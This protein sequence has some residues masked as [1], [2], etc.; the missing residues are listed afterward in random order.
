MYLHLINRMMLIIISCLMFTCSGHGSE[1]KEQE[2][3]KIG[4]T[5]PASSDVNENQTW[6]INAS[7]MLDVT[8]TQMSKSVKDF[9]ARIDTFFS[10]DRSLEEEN[11]DRLRLRLLSRFDEDGKVAFKQ[12]VS[13]HLKLPKIRKRLMLV[14]EELGEGDRLEDIKKE[15]NIEELNAV[16]RLILHETENERLDLDSG[17]S[18]KPEPNPIGRVRY[19]IDIDLGQWNFR[20]TQMI[21]W[22]LDDRFGETSRLDLE[23]HLFDRDLLRFTEEVT[24]WEVSSGVEFIATAAYLRAFSDRA[25]CGLFFNIFAHTR[26]SA[27]IDRYSLSFTY[28]LAIYKHWIYFQVEPILEALQEEDFRILHSIYLMLETVFP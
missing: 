13:L 19:R 16:V 5:L 1:K 14:L 22:K 4:A 26:P 23:R 6:Q 18:F 12:H 15:D 8:H 10:D 21:Y 3:E 11:G 25:G 17:M 27:M 7:K 28:R 24:W 20:P 9:A 2:N